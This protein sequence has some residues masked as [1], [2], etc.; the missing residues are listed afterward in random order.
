MI[1][2][3]NISK[4]FTTK[5]SKFHALKNVS[6]QI[7]ENSIH[8][9]IGPSGAGKSTIIR[10]INQLEEYDQGEVGV[11]EYKDIKKI[12]KES[13]RMLR[14]RIGMIFQEFNLLDR[15]TVFDNIAF[16][17]RLNGKLSNNDY[18]KIEKL[19]ETV[20]L[21][22]YE[23]SYP[24]QLSGGQKQ[25]VGIARALVNDPDILL[26]DEPTSALDTTTIKSILNL[27]KDLKDEFGLTVIIVTHDMNVIKEI[28]DFVTVMDKGEV[29]E[30]NTIDNIIFNPKSEI[31]KSLHGTVGLNVDELIKR[32]KD[33]DNLFLLRFEK[34]AQQDA[35]ISK[36]SIHFQVKINIL[37]ANIMLNE[38]GIML[39]NIDSKDNNTLIEINQSL[40]AKGVDVRNV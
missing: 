30:N 34:D 21:I 26:C 10:V 16:P 38:S 5:T 36:I 19:I 17:L 40:K 39:I 13:T 11:F 29:I 8:G 25:R 3:T 31:T 24:S 15:Q 12:N 1:N 37:Y 22:G 2:I 23:N 6:L 35:T 7:K 27:L 32:Y 9:I 4:T 28:C 18:K 33:F 20:G 14:K